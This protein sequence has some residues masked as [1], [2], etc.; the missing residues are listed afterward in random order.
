MTAHWLLSAEQFA[1]AWFETGMDRLPF[2]FRFTSR[3]PGSNEYQAYQ[4]Q[5]RTELAHEDHLPLRSAL[6]AIAQP[7]WRIELFGID[8]TRGAVEMRA[9]GCA[10][11]GG[12]GVIAVQVPAP[13]GGKVR[14]RRCRV[15]QLATDMVRLLP[16]PTAGPAAEKRYLLDDLN[17]DRPDPFGTAP[18]RAVREHYRRFWRQRCD[19]RGT[20]TVLLGPR[21]AAP[22]RTG[23]LRWIDTP[24]GRYSE[25]PAN[26]AL[27]IR[28]STSADITRY[29]DEAIIRGRTKLDR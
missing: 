21:N 13:D 22:S 11:R 28:P 18:S 24:Q 15:D 17:D 26:R 23:V 25:T 29:L 3:F 9:I 1:A 19:T 10:V 27:M 12:P 8:N 6:Q 5:F 16:N 4:R 7:D 14:L 2:P 20:A